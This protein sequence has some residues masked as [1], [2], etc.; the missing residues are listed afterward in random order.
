MAVIQAEMRAVRTGFEDFKTAINTELASLRNT[1]CEAERSLTPCSDDVESPK[2]GVKRV[3]ILTDY[4]INVKILNPDL[5][6]IISGLLVFLRVP[7]V[8]PPP[9]LHTYYRRLLN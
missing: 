2:R 6:E 7:T 1:Q 8:A 9:P 4:R 3:G 5:G